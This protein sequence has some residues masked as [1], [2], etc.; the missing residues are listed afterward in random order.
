MKTNKI[1]IILCVVML[2]VFVLFTVGQTLMG[3]TSE[4]DELLS[5]ARELAENELYFRSVEKYSDA[6]LKKDSLELRIE[7]LSV[8]DKGLNTNELGD[9]YD[10]FDAIEEMIEK[11]ME[12]AQA[13]EAASD[14][15]MKY[16]EYEKCAELLM[17]ARDLNVTSEKIETAREIVRYKYKSYYAMYTN[18]MPTYD[19]MIAVSSDKGA[20]YLD[21]TASPEL[22]GGYTYASSFSEG[23]AF[24][25]T[26]YSGEERGIIINKEG[27]RQAYMDGVT[28]SSGVGE[29]VR[30]GKKILLLAGLKDG[31][32]KY[33]GIDGVE[34]FGDYEFAG[35]YRNNVAAVKEANGWKL[36]NGDGVQIS[37]KIFEDVILNEFSECAPKGM[38]LAKENGAYHLY[39][40]KA[41][42]VGD[43]TCEN[44]KAY[45][46]GYIAVCVEGGWGYADSQGKMVIAPKYEDARSFSNGLGAVKKDGLWYLISPAEKVIGN[47]T[48]DDVG[49]LNEEGICFVRSSEYWSYIQMFYTGK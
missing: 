14:I 48:F 17:Q 45:A 9:T 49:Y 2:N 40:L 16:E 8:F 42:R 44:A 23:Y 32:Y 31:R 25:K 12:N 33:Y 29:A 28:E 18:V 43:L 21:S 27:Q 3:K 20:E 47:E 41:E 11:Y 5:E 1:L 39:D 46:D 38:I 10:Y 15:Y 13:Y 4:Y 19:G 34:V 36:I 37:D 35:R 26:A 6:I 24:V 7:Q 30:N 22:S